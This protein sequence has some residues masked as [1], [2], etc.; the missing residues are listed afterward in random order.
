[1]RVLESPYVS[2]R[3]SQVDFKAKALIFVHKDG[4][5]IDLECSSLGFWVM[6]CIGFI[7]SFSLIDLGLHSNVSPSLL[8]DINYEV[9]CSCCK[10][11]FDH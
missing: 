5:F 4:V 7:T 1:M 10:F 6:A 9:K 3:A 2:M 8:L 11:G